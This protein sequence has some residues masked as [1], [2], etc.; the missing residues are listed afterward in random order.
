MCRNAGQPSRGRAMSDAGWAEFSSLASRHRGAYSVN[1]SRSSRASS[2][3]T[4][5][6]TGHSLAS[7]RLSYLSP[8]EPA[9]PPAASGVLAEEFLNAPAIGRDQL[10]EAAELSALAKR[11]RFLTSMSANSL[12]VRRVR[13]RRFDKRP[14][15]RRWCRSRRFPGNTGPGRG[16]PHPRQVDGVAGVI[17]SSSGL[18]L[19]TLSAPGPGDQR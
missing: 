15:R 4:M 3:G 2:I 18:P 16:G 10:V 7:R 6:A 8:V 17:E 11:R 5:S 9:A 12:Q 13:S 19:E 14:R 1:T